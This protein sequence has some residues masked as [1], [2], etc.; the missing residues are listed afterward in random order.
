MDSMQEVFFK[1]IKMTVSIKNNK[2]STFLGF[3]WIVEQVVKQ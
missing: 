1:V 3:F 2:Q